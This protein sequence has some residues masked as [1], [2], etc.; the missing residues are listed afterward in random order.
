MRGASIGVC[1][2][3]DP[4]AYATGFFFKLNGNCCLPS[5]IA[6]EHEKRVIL[7]LRPTT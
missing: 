3:K 1:G 4:V 5:L 6:V 2:E 7:F